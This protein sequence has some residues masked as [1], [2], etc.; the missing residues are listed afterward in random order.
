VNALLASRRAD[1]EM[2]AQAVARDGSAGGGAGS[3]AGRS[4]GADAALEDANFDGICIDDAHKFDVGLLR[5]VEVETDFAAEFLPG[6]VVDGE[7]GV[8]G[9]DDVVGISGGD[10]DSSDF[11]SVGEHDGF[12]AKVGLAHSLLEFKLRAAGADEAAFAGA[13]VGFDAYGVAGAEL[14]VAGHPGGNAA[15]SVAGDF[16]SGAVGVDEV[17]AAGA[18]ARPLEELDAVG[19]DAGVAGAEFDGE[20][21]TGL[22]FDDEEVVAAGVGLG[23]VGHWCFLVPSQG[24]KPR[25]ILTAFW[26]G[27]SRAMIRNSGLFPTQ[28]K[29]LEWATLIIGDEGENRNDKYGRRAGRWNR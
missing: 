4:G 16:G 25:P 2:R 27:E 10:G 11:G 13:G 28:A 7:F 8:V 29:A 1:K 26:H 18:V 9:E 24:L 15:G 23:E 12:V 5:K 3:G 19:A 20:R 14:L 21:G 17:N 6:A 22:A